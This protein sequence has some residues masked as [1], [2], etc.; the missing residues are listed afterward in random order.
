MKTKIV[1]DTSV[2][3]EYIDKAGPWHKYARIIF[4]EIIR[5][6]I[7]AYIPIITLSEILYV[8]KRVYEKRRVQEPKKKALGLIRWLY[9]HPNIRIVVMRLRAIVLASLI[10]SKYRLSISNCYVIALAKLLKAKLFSGREREMFKH[11]N[12]LKRV[13]GVIFLEDY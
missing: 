10:K 2:I 1:I 11:V 12:I 6:R 13:Y 4:S 9:Q 3:V 7:V 5:E 8:A